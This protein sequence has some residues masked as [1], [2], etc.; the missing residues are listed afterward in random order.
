MPP[1][2]KPSPSAPAQELPAPSYPAVESLLE[3]TPAD[4][5]RALFAPVKEGL[6]E[7]KGPKVEQGKKAQAA[8]SRAEELLALLVETRERLLAEAKAPKGRK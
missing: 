6:A 3:A 8:I 4:E 7:L 5:V 2:A 1:S